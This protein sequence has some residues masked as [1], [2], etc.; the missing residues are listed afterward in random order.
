MGT[1]SARNRKLA[2]L[3]HTCSDNPVRAAGAEVGKM[4]Q[5]KMVIL[6]E[7]HQ[8]GSL[9][10]LVIDYL[11]S[12]AN[13]DYLTKERRGQ[14]VDLCTDL[15]KHSQPV[16]DP[17]AMQCALHFPDLIPTLIEAGANPK[18]FTPPQGKQHGMRLFDALVRNATA[19]SD[20][21][22]NR[23]AADFYRRAIDLGV[24]PNT[25]L[26][27][28]QAPALVET[29]LSVEGDL[30]L[31]DTIEYA[32]TKDTSEVNNLLFACLM[33]PEGAPLLAGIA[34][35]A[36]ADML[37]IPTFDNPDGKPFIELA[38]AEAEPFLL[39]VLEDYLPEAQAQAL[40][41]GTPGVKHQKFRRI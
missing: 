24:Y 4:M 17:I 35:K 9:L 10:A 6:Q 18:A 33:M 2:S 21:H 16:S 23:L 40:D 19:L 11:S 3:L 41:Q 7:E 29:A 26:N 37:H 31:L 34:I 8:P 5:E 32:L 12:G 20:A 14:L 25:A 27:E 39:S 28:C 15:A 22:G 1:I 13:V 38:R 30:F 36:G